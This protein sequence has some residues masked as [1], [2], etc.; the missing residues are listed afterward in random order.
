MSASSVALSVRNILGEKINMVKIIKRQPAL[1]CGVA[2]G[3]LALIPYVAKADIFWALLG[4]AMAA[5]LLIDS[6]ATPITLSK[7]AKAGLFAG[8][9]GGLI[10]IIVAT[11]LMANSILRYLVDST[12]SLQAKTAIESVY[13][14]PLIKYLIS[15][16]FSFAIMLLLMGLATIGSVLGTAIFER[17]PKQADAEISLEAEV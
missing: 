15:F 14:K 12:P 10:Y 4:G 17:R 7:G 13:Q 6:S 5:K 9:I 3:I 2:I 1:V 16:L 8:L 11:P